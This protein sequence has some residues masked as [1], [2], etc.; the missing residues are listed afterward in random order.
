MLTP[1][2]IK[3]VLNFFNAGLSAFIFLV[4]LAVSK[5]IGDIFLSAAMS[6]MIYLMFFCVIWLIFRVF[7]NIK[8]YE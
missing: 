7:F 2:K 3:T 1:K 6:S 8:A 5:S 4:F